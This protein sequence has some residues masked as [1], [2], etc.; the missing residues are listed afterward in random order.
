MLTYCDS[1]VWYVP[2][3]AGAHAARL[4]ASMPIPRP[5]LARRVLVKAG[6]EGSV[7][8]QWAVDRLVPYEQRLIEPIP[9]VYFTPNPADD[10]VCLATLRKRPA[11]EIVLN[12]EVEW[13]GV[14]PDTVQRR[15]NGLRAKLRAAGFAIPIGFSS[16]ASWD[17]FPYPAFSAAC[18][19]T[20]QVQAY[21]RPDRADQIAPLLRKSRQGARIVVGLPAC[22][23][24]DAGGDNQA[25][26]LAS[27]R[28]L[29]TYYATGTR[30]LRG[31][32]GWQ[33]GATAPGGN[34]R[35]DFAHEAMQFAY[36]LLPAFGAPDPEVVAGSK[37]AGARNLPYNVA[38]DNPAVWHCLL[39]D[40]SLDVWV[41]RPE[42]VAK[43]E[44]YGIHALEVFG[45]PIAGMHPDAAGML[46]Q[47]FERA[48]M[49]L[50]AP[51][52]VTL[53]RVGW[54][55]LQR[56]SAAQVAASIGMLSFA[57]EPA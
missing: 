1:W 7:W 37:L 28:D 26:T 45:L 30:D 32:N 55:A 15:I 2:A 6:G 22:L 51:G 46:V 34:A 44:E 31:F 9:W 16:V 35:P 13:G 4:A 49:E 25:W 3:D 43:Y 21:W 48:R 18:D 5:D 11:S 12:V 47:Y 17:W 36:T 41:I 29:A 54:E 19:G 40:G 53:G 23:S 14:S 52:I 20:E 50:A 33:S 57:G 10:E 42:F 27:L 38:A 8:Q 24:E 56:E 39:P